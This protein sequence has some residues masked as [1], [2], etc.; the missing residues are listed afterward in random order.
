MW[1]CSQQ[2][3]PGTNWEALTFGCSWKGIAGCTHCQH[4]SQ[5][6]S[7]ME[8]MFSSRSFA[9]MCHPHYLSP[10]SLL[11]SFVENQ[12]VNDYVCEEKWNYTKIRSSL[13]FYMKQ[14]PL[15]LQVRFLKGCSQNIFWLTMESTLLLLLLSKRVRQSTWSLT[16]RT[17]LCITSTVLE[18]MIMAQWTAGAM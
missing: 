18:F 14:C 13:N 2:E 8:W 6:M 15:V 17:Q 3:V 4:N 12:E 9:W 1:C 5:L 10:W 11:E 16:K 7:W